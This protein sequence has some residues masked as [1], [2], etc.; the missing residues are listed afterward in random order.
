MVTSF[1][2]SACD[3]VDLAFHQRLSIRHCGTREGDF[4]RWRQ[5]LSG[6]GLIELRRGA[7]VIIANTLNSE[8]VL[9]GKGATDEVLFACGCALDVRWLCL[10]VSPQL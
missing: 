7:S 2:V 1:V 3:F 10:V 4:N 6:M 9:I 5:P 8:I